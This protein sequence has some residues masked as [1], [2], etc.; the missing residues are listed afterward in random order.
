MEIKK[1]KV[2]KGEALWM[3]T[4]SDLSFILMC[5]FALLLSMSTV[6]SQKFD[7]VAGN[8][9]AK[10]PD[11]KKKEKNL[12]AIKESVEKTVKK[13]ESTRRPKRDG[14]D[15]QIRRHPCAP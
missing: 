6:N 2:K 11:Q 14:L 7:N 5:F 4:F 10:I 1:P 8:L 13:K 12:K 15:R 3:M 9:A